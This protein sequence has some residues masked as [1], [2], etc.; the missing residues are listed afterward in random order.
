M[1]PLSTSSD[2]LALFDAALATGDAGRARRRGSTSPALRARG[3]GPAAAARPGPR[4]G[5]AAAAVG[6]AT[7]TRWAGCR[8]CAAAER[9]RRVLDLVR[10][11]VAAVLGHASAD[12]GRTRAGPSSDLGFDS[13]TAVELRNR[14]GTATGPAAAATL[15]FDYPTAAR[16]PAT[17]STNCPDR[18]P[19]AAGRARRS[20]PPTTRS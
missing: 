1:P 17:W 6:A 3:R 18:G 10:D 16:W 20:S 8:R 12:G 14:L 7:A 19:T 15:V 4:A 9:T 5:R 2:G 13:L 11:Q